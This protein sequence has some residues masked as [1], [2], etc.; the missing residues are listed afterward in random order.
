M[1][2]TLC[3]MIKRKRIQVVMQPYLIYK[4]TYLVSL[5]L[6]LEYKRGNAVNGVPISGLILESSNGVLVRWASGECS[7]KETNDNSR[8]RPRVM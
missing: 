8:A 6:L 4:H 1:N 3:H 7:R 2:I 5:L